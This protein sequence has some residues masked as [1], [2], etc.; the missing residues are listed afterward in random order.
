METENQDYKNELEESVDRFIASIK[1]F[2]EREIEKVTEMASAI[3]ESIKRG[4]TIYSCGNGG[5]AADSQHI[6]GEF[7][8]RFLLDRRPLPFVSLNTDTSVLTCVGNDFGFDY[9]FSRQIEALGRK[10]DIFIVFST[11]GNSKNI[12]IAVEAAK[13][14]GLKVLSFTGEKGSKLEKESDICLCSGIRETYLTQ[15]IH[16]LAYHLIC[17][18]VEEKLFPSR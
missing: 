7:I 3:A 14:I 5:S 17:K 16:Q 15:Q 10:D 8:G 2:K 4:N 6:A 1:V 11:S 9:I 18:I 13:K 12:I